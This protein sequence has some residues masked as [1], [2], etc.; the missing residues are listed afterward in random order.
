MTSGDDFKETDARI[1]AEI[2]G[3]LAEMAEQ[4]GYHA[5]TCY[6]DWTPDR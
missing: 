5:E 3:D 6:C 1:R 4:G 2:D